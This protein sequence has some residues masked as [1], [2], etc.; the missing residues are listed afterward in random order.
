MDEQNKLQ[1]FNFEEQEV[2]IIM[3]DNKP[4]WVARDVCNV[5]SIQ[6]ITQAMHQLNKDEK[7][8]HKGYYANQNRNMWL[9]DEAGLYTLIL[10]SNKP[11]A[12][13]FKKWIT[14]DILPTIR[15]T[16]VFAINNIFEL[17]KN[18]DFDDIPTQ[19][20]YVYVAQEEYSKRFKI[21]ISKNPDKRVKALNIGNPEKLIIV[22]MFKAEEAGHLSETKMHKYF[23]E[24]HLRGEWFDKNISIQNYP[25]VDIVAGVH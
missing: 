12:I 17:L 10:R 13:Q 14:H 21:G 1:I 19:D 23:S 25:L 22:T 7:L 24:Y 8:T 4:W 6:N 15:K 5:L 18:M 16:G 11:R 3:I 2:R 20:R 9:I